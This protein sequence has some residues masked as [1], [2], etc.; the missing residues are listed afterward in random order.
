M[1]PITPPPSCNKSRFLEL[2]RIREVSMVFIWVRKKS[3]FKR[4]EGATLRERREAGVNI[5]NKFVSQRFKVRGPREVRAEVFVRVSSLLGRGE[6]FKTRSRAAECALWASF[7]ESSQFQACESF[8][9]PDAASGG[10]KSHKGDLVWRFAP[11]SRE[12][13]LKQ[14][15]KLPEG[16]VGQ[17]RINICKPEGDPKERRKLV[18]RQQK[19]LG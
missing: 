10:V 17:D 2:R 16:K 8:V 5:A 15:W 14:S 6:K 4:E 19:L 7:N 12:H 11:F 3:S 13:W 9:F 18:N 1:F